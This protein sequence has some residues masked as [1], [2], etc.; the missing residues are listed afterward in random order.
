MNQKNEQSFEYELLHHTLMYLIS[1]GSQGKS[2]ATKKGFA[3]RYSSR[4]IFGDNGKILGKYSN[5]MVGI[6]VA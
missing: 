3:L 4:E 2:L 6:L 1:K 5:F